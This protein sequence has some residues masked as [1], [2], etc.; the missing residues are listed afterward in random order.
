[1]NTLSKILYSFMFSTLIVSHALDFAM[2]KPFNMWKFNCM[3][4]VSVAFLNELRVNKIGK[5]L[6]DLQ[7]GSK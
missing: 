5:Q 6:K 2:D 3:M 1:M 4:W 7:D